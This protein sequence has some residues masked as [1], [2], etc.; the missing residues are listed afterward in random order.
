MISNLRRKISLLLFAMEALLV[1]VFFFA[2]NWGNYQRNLDEL[3][4]NMR[5]TIRDSDI[6]WND[7]LEAKSGDDIDFGDNGYCVFRVDDNAQVSVCFNR[8]PGESEERM[9]KCAQ[10]LASHWRSSDD[11]LRYGYL[12]IRTRKN[13][14]FIVLIDGAQALH[15]SLPVMAFSGG[16]CAVLLLLLAFLMQRLSVWLLAPIEAMMESEKTFV[17]NASHELKTPLAVISAN[18]EL[19]ADGL[20]EQNKHLQ[21]IRQETEHMTRLVNRMLA[22]VRLDAPYAEEKYEKFS[23]DEVLLNVCY[24]MESIAYEKG[25]RMEIDSDSQLWLTGVP[26]QIRSVLSILVDN[27]ISYT[28]PGGRITVCSY[29]S[30]GRILIRVANTGEPI[31]PKLRKRLFERYF[32]NDPSPEEAEGHFGLGLS[33]AGRIVEHHHGSIRVD[34]ANGENIFEV[35]LPVH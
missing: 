34:S 28:A 1:V 33:I 2:F 24:P 8:F 11:L 20:G 12:Y 23:L 30:N 5:S 21:N 13:G 18:T 4:E 17:S 25:I 14:K 7:F 26:D 31:P 10:R 16:C 22:L 29:G 27:A 15:A 19:L 35:S 9:Q 3:G 32:R 6:S